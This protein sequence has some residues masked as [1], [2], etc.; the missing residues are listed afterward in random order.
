ME[1]DHLVIA[2]QTLEEGAAWLEARTGVRAQAGGKHALMST[3]NLLARLNETAYLEIIS[4]DPDAPKPTRARWFDLDRLELGTPRLIHWVAR[5]TN[6]EQDHARSLEP[7]GIVTPLTRGA[8]AW[9]ITIP[10]DGHLPGDGLLPTLIQWDTPN[11]SANLEPRG[12]NLLQIEGE[13][14][15][16]PRIN[17]SLESLGVSW[18][19]TAGERPVLKALLETPIGQVWL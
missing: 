19:I 7:L 8:Y 9:R 1:L 4:I 6:I 5:S 17:S 16:A 3:H 18:R 13:H 10:D 14:P 15:N 12:L 2:A 11:P